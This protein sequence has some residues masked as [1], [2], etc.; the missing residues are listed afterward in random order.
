MKKRLYRTILLFSSCLLTLFL[1][2]FSFPEPSPKD[3]AVWPLPPDQPRISYVMAIEKPRDIGVKKSFF[4]RV[5]EFV[6]GKEPEPKILRPSGITSDGNGTVYIADTGLQVVHVFDFN[7]R[8]Y[9]QVFIRHLND[10]LGSSE[11]TRG[12]LDF[13]LDCNYFLED[14]HKKLDKQYDEVSAMLFAL[15]EKWQTF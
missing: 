3:K 2:G 11:E 7:K 15:M 13:S 12:W 14:T 4:R 9:R 1:F 8:R 6:A 10:G 5:L